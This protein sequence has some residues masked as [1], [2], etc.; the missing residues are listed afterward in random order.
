MF[1]YVQINKVEFEEEEKNIQNNI[2]VFFFV[3]CTTKHLEI[4]CVGGEVNAIY[5]IHSCSFCCSLQ[6]IAR[7]SKLNGVFISLCLLVFCRTHTHTLVGL[8]LG[9]CLIEIEFILHSNYCCPC[10]CLHLF[11]VNAFLDNCNLSHAIRCECVC[12]CDLCHFSIVFIRA[13]IKS[14]TLQNGILMQSMRCIFE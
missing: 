12:V 6:I 14:H 9:F 3:Y 5:N 1:I 7:M 10:M 8:G 2:L 13:L 4:E 11:F